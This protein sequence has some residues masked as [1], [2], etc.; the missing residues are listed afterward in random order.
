MR[1][2]SAPVGHAQARASFAAVADPVRRASE[3]H[4]FELHEAGRGAPIRCR[5]DPATL[6]GD[7]GCSAAEP[8]ESGAF[9]ACAAAFL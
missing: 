6:N 9:A 5:G 7:E 4:L 1:K 2:H 8:L 3:A